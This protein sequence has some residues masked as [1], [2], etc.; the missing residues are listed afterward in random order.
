MLK[1]S[2]L[3]FSLFSIT[4]LSLVPT[5]AQ[6]REDKIVGV[7]TKV[8][9]NTVEVRTDSKETASVTLGPD[10]RYLK[11]IMAKPWQQDPRTNARFLHVGSRVRIEA[12]QDNP[13]TARTVWIVVGR[14]GF[15]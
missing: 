6:A 3:A 7:V 8:E 9:A 15:D 12:A 14:P 1:R 2:L 13:R 10:T 5:L 11:W 4:A